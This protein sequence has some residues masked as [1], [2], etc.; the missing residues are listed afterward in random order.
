MSRLRALWDQLGA[1]FGTVVCLAGFIVLFF[2]WNGAASH[3]RVPAQFPYLISAGLAGLGLIV[4]G[5][6]LIVVDGNRRTADDLRATIEQ[7]RDALEASGA[8]STNGVR[9]AVASGMVV[10]GASSYHRPDCHLVEGRDGA[11]IISVDEAEEEGLS[12]CRICKPKD[13]TLSR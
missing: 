7:L 13:R 4:V 1:K 12:A 6:A 9:S 10:A 11:R 5:A 3:D 8:A 2:G